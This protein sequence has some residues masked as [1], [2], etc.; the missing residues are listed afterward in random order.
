MEFQRSV[1]N[2]LP[3]RA[4]A[5]NE[6]AP[7]TDAIA[8]ASGVSAVADLTV[9]TVVSADAKVVPAPVT[10]GP[11][12]FPQ[13]IGGPVFVADTITI[14]IQGEGYQELKAVL[15]ELTEQIRKSNEA[16]V[17][18]RRQLTGQLAA[19]QIIAETPKPDRGALRKYL[20]DTLRSIVQE[21]KSQGI[22]DLAAKAL[23]LLWHI[24]SGLFS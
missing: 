20:V 7:P 18:V 11:T 17:E 14:N 16:A 2:L 8:P 21:F 12:I 6:A 3:P 9:A 1:D 13:G 5:A 4:E 24:A 23:K 15:G 22:R 10:L 19:G